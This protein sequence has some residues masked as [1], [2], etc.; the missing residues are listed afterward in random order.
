MSKSSALLTK[1][2][3]EEAVRLVTPAIHEIIKL[4]SNRNVIYI[5]VFGPLADNQEQ[6]I[7][8][9]AVGEQNKDK[10]AKDY[11]E[12]ALAKATVTLQ[13]GLPSH[14]VQHE[15]AHLYVEGDFKFGGSEIRKGIIVGASG[16]AWRR[17]YA[18]SA[19]LAAVIDALVKGAF[20]AEYAR[21][22]LFI[23]ALEEK[24]AN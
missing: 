13:T 22:A 4:D 16:L 6:P 12:F 23:G 8:Q 7:W 1:T 2:L 21:R 10:W 5:A 18:V 20:D 24:P 15:F 17:D 14:I 11:S 9:G 19:M 3:V